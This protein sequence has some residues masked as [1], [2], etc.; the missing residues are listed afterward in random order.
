MSSYM[1][2]M[3]ACLAVL[4]REEKLRQQTAGKW[5]TTLTLRP[6]S[7]NPVADLTRSI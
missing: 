3:E 1:D 4:L 6:T 5:A 7:V 2:L